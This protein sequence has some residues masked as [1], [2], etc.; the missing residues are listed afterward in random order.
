METKNIKRNHFSIRRFNLGSEFDD[1]T[2]NRSSKN[3][4]IQ[5]FLKILNYHLKIIL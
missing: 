2:L 4:M 1:T 3:F 5:I